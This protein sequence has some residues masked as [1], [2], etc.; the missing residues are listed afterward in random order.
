VLPLRHHGLTLALIGRAMLA[1]E[2]RPDGWT[3]PGQAV[4]L[5]LSM[6]ARSRSL[7]WHPRLGS[8]AEPATT[9]AERAV[10]LFPARSYFYELGTRGLV[11]ARLGL[12]AVPPDGWYAAGTP[13]VLLQTGLGGVVPESVLLFAAGDRPYAGRSSVELC[14][15]VPPYAA[16]IQGPACRSCSATLVGSQCAFCGCGPVGELDPQTGLPAA[17]APAERGVLL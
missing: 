13:P 6:A 8:I 11:P 2:L 9:L 14:R 17:A 16:P 1:A 3:D 5:V 15:L 12:G 4:Q 7:V 10:S